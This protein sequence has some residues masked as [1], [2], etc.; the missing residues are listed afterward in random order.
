MIALVIQAM[1]EVRRQ[2]LNTRVEQLAKALS[3]ADPKTR[4]N[5]AV[6]HAQEPP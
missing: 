1:D 3:G 5:P 6:R 2:E 4:R